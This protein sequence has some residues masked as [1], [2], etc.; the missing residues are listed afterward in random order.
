M[1]LV[2]LNTNSTWA[3]VMG[4]SLI[5]LDGECLFFHDRKTAVAIAHRHSIFVDESGQCFAGPDVAESIDTRRP[6]DV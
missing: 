3:F 6:Q 1:K 5:R 4:D 2:F